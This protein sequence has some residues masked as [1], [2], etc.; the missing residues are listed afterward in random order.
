MPRWGGVRPWW[1]M[2][3]IVPGGGNCTVRCG[4]HAWN[5]PG[6]RC[7]WAVWSRCCASR[8]RRR[9]W[10][11]NR[12]T[13]PATRMVKVGREVPRA[14][15]GDREA[16]RTVRR[17]PDSSVGTA[18]HRHPEHHGTR[19]RSS[20]QRRTGRSSV[21]DP[22]QVIGVIIIA[23]VAVFVIVAIAKSSKIV[24]QA[25][26]LIVERLGRYQS[27]MYAGLHFLIPFVDRVRS[28][29]DLRERVVPFQPQPVITSD[30]LVVNIDTV[31]Y[32]S[33]T[34]PKA[35]TYEIRSE[36][37]RVGEE[38][39][40][41]IR[42]TRSKRDWSS[43]VCSSDLLPVHHV[44]GVALPDPIRGPGALRGGPA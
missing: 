19:A 11:R 16:P 18:E 23:L 25:G 36:E 4:R 41:H 6:W 9:S 2:S 12:P 22:G 3:P 7:R 17:R 30:N 21:E 26:A 33:V 5:S 43:D 38:D 40:R 15:P 1:P 37:R 35:A 27:T 31:V 44:R 13:T 42:H 29:V 32:F 39:E 28:G 34:D 10:P 8:G 24:P 20:A 14:D